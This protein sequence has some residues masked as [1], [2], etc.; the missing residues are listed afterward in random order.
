MR[1]P[2]ALELVPI[3]WVDALRTPEHDPSDDG[4]TPC[5]C[6]LAHGLCTQGIDQWLNR[7]GAPRG[8]T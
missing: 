1:E 7:A 2:R 8:G 5:P 6:Y 3:V 4:R